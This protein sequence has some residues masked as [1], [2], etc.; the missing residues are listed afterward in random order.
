MCFSTIALAFAFLP[1]RNSH[2]I[3]GRP[4]TRD[5][6]E[7]DVNEMFANSPLFSPWDA[8]R[9]TGYHSEGTVHDILK[10]ILLHYRK[11]SF[12]MNLER[13]GMVS[14]QTHY[15]TNL[16]AETAN[17]QQKCK[18]I[19]QPQSLELSQED[20]YEGGSRNYVAT[21]SPFWQLRSFFKFSSEN[22]SEIGKDM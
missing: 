19:F 14:S 10:I 15:Q 4:S 9:R 20:L 3:S 16:F 8:L 21:L 7:K 18:Q 13:L 12:F 11:S 22:V 2:W 6:T 17:S 5:E 1:A